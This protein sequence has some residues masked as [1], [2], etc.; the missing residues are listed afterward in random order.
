MAGPEDEMDL[1]PTPSPNEG[2][3]VDRDSQRSSVGLLGESGAS[4]G[5][6]HSTQSARHLRDLVYGPI[7]TRPLR[8][9]SFIP[10]PHSDELAQDAHLR[11]RARQHVQRRS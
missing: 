2:F 9:R 11:H 8:S 3:A 10:F 7:L 1:P 6:Q 4:F 5:F